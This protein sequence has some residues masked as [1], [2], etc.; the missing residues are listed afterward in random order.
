MSESLTIDCRQ[1]TQALDRLM[2][3]CVGSC[4]A[5]LSL[6]ED[7]REHFRLMQQTIGFRRIRFHAIL[8][9]LVG[10]YDEKEE[11]AP[12]YNFQ[13][14]DK[15]YDFFLEE[16]CRPFV[17]IGFMPE[18][19][20]SESDTIFK[21]R[22]LT[23][24]PKD[25]GKWIE[26]IAAFARH[27]IDRYGLNEV[28]SWH[29]E[30]WNEPNLGGFWT[31]GL[32]GYLRLYQI[33]TEALKSVHP[34]I[35]VGGPATA[36]IQWVDRLLTFCAEKGVPIDF[37]TT[38]HY[39]A[40]VGLVMNK[41]TRPF[42]YCGWRHM[43]ANVKTIREQ[44]AQSHRPDL[45]IYFTEWNVSPCHE[46]VIGKD[47]EFTATFALQVLRAMRGR[48]D[49][50]AIWTF[51]DIFEESGP[52]LYPFSGKYG[53]I[54]LHGIPKPVY[55]AYRFLA[56]LYES[57]LPVESESSIFTCSGA[58]DVRFLTWHL[59][60]PTDT[61]FAGGEWTFPEKT[62]TRHVRL[63]GL[64]G[65]YRVRC[66]RVDAR[67]GNALRAWQAMGSPQYLSRD[68]VEALKFAAEPELE[69]DEIRELDGS[70][71]IDIELD[72]NAVVFCDLERV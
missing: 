61:N 70:F 45:P 54:N 33:T 39:C 43:T 67:H 24:P 1:P 18:K 3:E 11:S 59:V 4:H 63:Q 27:L 36:G 60:E 58:G 52:G 9:D 48:L 46:D 29:F 53:L 49:G 16:G 23:S 30:V 37:V 42:K 64:H 5:Y 14:V 34:L 32:D 13:N 8:H 25:E 40:N 21:Y 44:V 38:H 31:G 71:D 50:Y 47:S 17:E 66:L 62:Q 22:G 10:V 15:I 20:A 7:Y 55:H 2:R 28:L 68:Q 26:L 72:G 19:L 56:D 69:R 51:T 41:P 12:V 57:E 35:R 6:R 65:R